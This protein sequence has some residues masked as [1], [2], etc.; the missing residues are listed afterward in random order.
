MDLDAESLHVL[1]LVE[2]F[3]FV[4]DW[5]VQCGSSGEYVPFDLNLVDVAHIYGRNDAADA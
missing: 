3:V 1:S 2:S 5:F 4:N